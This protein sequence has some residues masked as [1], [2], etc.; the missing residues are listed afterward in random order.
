MIETPW[1]AET[2]GRLAA[3]IHLKIPRSEIRSAMG[4]AI[5]EVM[6]AVKAQ[7]VEPSGP[8]FTHHLK[9]IPAEFDFEVCVPVGVP[10]AAKGS[11]VCREV[12]AGRVARTIHHGPYDGPE[13]LAAAWGEFSGWVA[14]NG[15]VAG[16]DLYECYLV[17]PE[18]SSDPAAWR[19]EL[20]RPLQRSHS[21]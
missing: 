5:G 4:P 17:G 19:T 18:T 15:H 14:A 2:T 7:G 8:W 16:E 3:M 12:C 20:S 6:A 9:M 11:V 1:I 13:G 21:E 10:V